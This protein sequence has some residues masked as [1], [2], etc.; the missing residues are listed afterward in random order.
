[1]GLICVAAYRGPIIAS[2]PRVPVDSVDP[3]WRLVIG[4]GCVPGVIALYF[5][6]TVPET[7][8]FTMDI[9]GN[10]QQA[11]SDIRAVIGGGGGYLDPDAVVHRAEAPRAS[12]SD[13]CAYFGKWENGRALLG[14]SWSWFALN[15]GDRPLW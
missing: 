3:I 8:R 9:E 4:L 10:I 1:V 12:W 5:R 11:M 6:L 14:T 2:P 15:V 7:P 13:F